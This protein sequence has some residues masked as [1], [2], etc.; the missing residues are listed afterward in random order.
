MHRH[1]GTK[2]PPLP[3]PLHR[4]SP[5]QRDRTITPSLVPR[6]GR[7]SVSASDLKRLPSF[8]SRNDFLSCVLL[9]SYFSPLARCVVRGDYIG[10]RVKR[11]RFPDELYDVLVKENVKEGCCSIDVNMLTLTAE[12]LLN[13]PSC[14]R[15]K[16]KEMRGA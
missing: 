2:T 1:R 10:H 8:Y 14:V 4:P 9:V 7:G 5:R 15:R 6:I 13:T 11:K 12:V 3:P 16:H